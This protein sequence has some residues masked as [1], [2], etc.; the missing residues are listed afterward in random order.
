MA[1]DKINNSHFSDTVAIVG[2][3]KSPRKLLIVDVASGFANATVK[4][5]NITGLERDLVSGAAVV[6]PDQSILFCGGSGREN[7]SSSWLPVP[8]NSCY[9]LDP[10]TGIRTD[11]PPLPV[12]VQTQAMVVDG[13]SAYSFG[14]EDTAG[15]PNRTFYNTVYVLRNGSWREV[16]PMASKRS[17]ISAVIW[18][19]KLY[20]IGGWNG[21]YSRDNDMYL[22]RVEALDLASGAWSNCSSMP[23][24][25]SFAGSAVYDGHIYVCGGHAQ[26]HGWKPL[27]D[28]FLYSPSSDSWSPGPMMARGRHAFALLVIRGHLYAVGG[29]RGFGFR[30]VERLNPETQQWELLPGELHV[31][32]VLA[33]YVVL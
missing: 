20:A 11:A 33:G 21:T 31:E 23:W 18:D 25:V 10:L 22:N 4:Y 32:K 16:A 8:Y 29:D 26:S 6:L 14:G 13:D 28:C 5:D 12:A 15:Y 2:G 1:V 27:R 3:I 7:G 9:R 30:S 24:G 17:R 19:G